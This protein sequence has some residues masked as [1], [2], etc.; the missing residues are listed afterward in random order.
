VY[1]LYYSPSTASLVIHWLLLELGVPFEL[2]L[3]DLQSRQQQTPEYL[4]LNPNGH[5]PALLIDGV[6]RAET[7]AL[8]LLLAERHPQ[9]RLAPVPGSR[10]RADFL[11]V[12]FFLDNT[13]MPAFRRWF[14]ADEFAGPANREATMQQAR[15]KIER[16]WDVLDAR[17][18]DGRRYLLGADRGVVDFLATMLARW[19]RNMPRT[20]T[21]WPHLRRYVA[22]MRQLPSLRE[23]HAREKLTDWIND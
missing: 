5:V 21:H 17:L 1:T 23:V 2:V 3:V 20:A 9:A 14:Y 8:L 19:S 4:A 10:E 22:H 12:L 18:A 11:Q 16:C 15:L 6:V 7:G 13:L